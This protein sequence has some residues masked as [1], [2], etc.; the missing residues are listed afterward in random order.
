[1]I[2]ITKEPNA[3]S[4]TAKNYDVLPAEQ[5]K[6][7]TENHI[8]HVTAGLKFFADLLLEAGKKH[9][10]LKLEK[11][12]EF[13]EALKSGKIKESAW[14]QEHK[15]K[16]RHHLKAHVPED[17]NLIDVFEHLVDCVMAALSRSGDL[18][19]VDLDPRML[20]TALKNTI[21]LLKKEVKVSEAP[22]DPMDT[23]L[24]DE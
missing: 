6:R 1:M 12:K 4:R 13:H 15:T 7:A 19:D 16:E 10:H 24:N 5:L 21:E 8:E 14:Y 11:F 9:D 18:Y 20:E 2:E 17:V 3:D 23:K 22:E